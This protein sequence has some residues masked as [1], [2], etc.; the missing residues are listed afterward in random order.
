M[1]GDDYRNSICVGVSGL[2]V[3]GRLAQRG[4]LEE[5]A[6]PLSGCDSVGLIDVLQGPIRWLN[7]AACNSPYSSMTGHRILCGVPDSDLTQSLPRA[8]IRP[9]LVRQVPIVGKVV[10]LRWKGKDHAK[11]VM[12]SL[13]NDS[14]L[15]QL[16]LGANKEMGFWD[17]P[18]IEWN[19]RLHPDLWM[20][21][22][23]PVFGVERLTRP[24]TWECL[25]KIA[26]YLA[27]T[28]ISASS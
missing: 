28:S 4:R 9:V 6:G 5:K 16:M 23:G 22:I 15:K 8:K 3:D 2:G 26:Q 13:D 1:S 17:D 27:P 24:K 10:A 25:Q 14:S 7:V 12:D 21:V 19:I 18:G 20:W 11:G